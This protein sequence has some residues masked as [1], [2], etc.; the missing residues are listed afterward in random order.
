MFDLSRRVALVTG[1]GQGVGAEVARTLARQGAA[2]AVNDLFAARA[3]T[4]ADEIIASGGRAEAVDADITDVD[5]V[6]AMVATVEARVG[7]VDILVNNA[8]VTFYSQV[9][10]FDMRRWELMLEVQVRA[11]FELAGMVL[12]GMRARRRGWILNISSKSS[13]HPK[14]PPYP[15]MAKRGGTMYGMCKAALE[16][17]TSGLAA[18][19]Y[20]DGIAVNCLSPSRVVATPGVIHHKLIP[21]GQEHIAEPVDVMAEAAYLLVSGDPSTRTGLIT[22]SQD[23]VDAEAPEEL[24]A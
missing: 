18:E 2:V 8:A 24:R 16:R 3:R 12:P 6:G 20:D 14:G 1:A 7:P 21:P 19:V 22:F 4:V 15:A 23:V 11:P 10:D 13:F 5:A 9:A 17:F